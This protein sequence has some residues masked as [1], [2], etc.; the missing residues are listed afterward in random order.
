MP[1]C[2]CA[3]GAPQPM[4]PFWSQQWSAQLL[5]SSLRGHP[6][7]RPCASDQLPL[8]GLQT[9]GRPWPAAARS[10]MLCTC[11]S[12]PRACPAGHSDC[13]QELPAPEGPEHPADMFLIQYTPIIAHVHASATVHENMCHS[14]ESG[15]PH[16]ESL[17]CSLLPLCTQVCFFPCQCVW[18]GHMSCF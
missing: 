11:L 3:Q 2:V 10:R 8:Q 15:E 17:L 1:H 16:H 18:C 12:G 5:P 6:V 9:S 7:G 4:L 13:Y 14:D